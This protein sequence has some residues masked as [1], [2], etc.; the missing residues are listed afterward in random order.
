MS[1]SPKVDG[2]HTLPL[3]YVGSGRPEDFAGRDVRG[4]IALIQRTTGMTFNSQINNAENAGAAVAVIY[5]NRPGLLLGYGGDAGTIPIPAFSIDQDPGQMLV[6]LL[7]QGQV[8][9]A[10]SGTSMS[11][12][13]Y[14]LML[15]NPDRIADSQ[16]YVI[17][18]SNTARIDADYYAHVDGQL[19][20]DVMHGLRPWTSFAFGFARE[21]PRP[22]QRTEWVSTGDTT[23]WHIAWSNYPFDGEFDGLLTRYAAGERRSESTFLQPVRPGIPEGPTGWEDFG[24]PPYREGDE[25]VVTEFPY[26]DNSYFG[27]G[28]AGD[29]ASTKLYRGSQL[30]AEGTYPV[31]TYEVPVAGSATYRLESVLKRP[32]P[33]WRYSTEVDTAWTFTS[34]RPAS[35]REFLPML[36]VD[37]DLDLD[38]WNRA[39]DRS[40]YDF[41]FRP[42]YAPG[43]GEAEV[44]SVKAWASF[45]DGGTWKRI[46]VHDLGNGGYEAVVQHPAVGKTSGAVSLRVQATDAEGN[47][48][49]QTI[50]RAYGLA[51]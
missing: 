15:P 3:V 10:Y 47:A 6:D 29:V 51:G 23:W 1:N 4:K 30:L 43:A 5:N 49:D 38:L 7:Q 11:P 9:V 24:A 41:Q 31:D 32:L 37:Y 2:N 20:T 50:L 16:T 28:T 33:W 25:L 34:Q 46:S 19:G 40:A 8:R 39:P 42:R 12:Y 21:L 27:W 14:E 45:N 36:Q 35:G 22:Q 18:K 26:S 17:D 48:V 13:T 44:A